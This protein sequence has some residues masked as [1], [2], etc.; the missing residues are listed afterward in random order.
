MAL[1]TSFLFLYVY[2]V[3]FQVITPLPKSDHVSTLKH[4]GLHRLLEERSLGGIHHMCF[5]VPIL[6]KAVR[7]VISN[8]GVAYTRYKTCVF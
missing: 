1:F 8:R 3:F 2:F 5:Q 7:D 6:E 4:R